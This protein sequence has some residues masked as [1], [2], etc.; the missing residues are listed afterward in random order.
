M[1]SIPYAAS[2]HD[3]SGESRNVVMNVTGNPAASIAKTHNRLVKTRFIRRMCSS[4]KVPASL[5]EFSVC[6]HALLVA[7]GD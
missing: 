5:P 3:H 7:A 2:I 4:P 1:D 6:S